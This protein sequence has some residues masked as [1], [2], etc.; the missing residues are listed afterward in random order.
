MNLFFW[1]GYL[2]REALTKRDGLGLSTLPRVKV[3]GRHLMPKYDPL[4]PPTPLVS[5][6]QLQPKH[7][8]GPAVRALL[9]G[10]G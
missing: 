5:L 6:G 3:V 4:P 2:P 9:G 8:D 10:H 1:G 7:L